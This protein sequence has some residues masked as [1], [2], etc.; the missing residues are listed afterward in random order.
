MRFN[1]SF[2]AMN[3][4]VMRQEPAE[5][6]NRNVCAGSNTREPMRFKS[7]FLWVASSRLWLQR[8]VVLD[9]ANLIY[10]IINHTITYNL[11]T[12]TG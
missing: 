3:L 7:K 4:A 10:Y 6:P 12:E 5:S 9:F 11:L 8:F 2:D 1:F